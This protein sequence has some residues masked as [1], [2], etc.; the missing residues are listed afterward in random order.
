MRFFRFRKSTSNE[1]LIIASTLIVKYDLRSFSN[2]L[3]ELT[4]FSPTEASVNVPVQARVAWKP[5]MII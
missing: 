1:R 5:I 3:E 4:S 2:I